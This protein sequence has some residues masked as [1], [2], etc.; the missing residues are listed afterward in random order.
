MQEAAKDFAAGTVAGMSCK[1]VEYPLDTVKVRLQ[2][3][4]SV[5]LSSTDCIARMLKE[6][7][8]LSFYRGV[9]APMCG[10]MFETAIAFVVYGRCLAYLDERRKS[11][12]DMIR[13]TDNLFAGGAS[14][15]ATA[16]VLTPIELVKCRL[17]VQE[18]LAPAQRLH[19]GPL[20]CVL[21]TLRTEGIRGMFLG[22]TPCL[23]REIPGNAVWYGVYS[24]AK[25]YLPKES[26]SGQAPMYQVAMAGSLAGIAYWTAFFPADVVKTRIQVD[27][28]KRQYTL[29]GAF[30]DV[31]REGGF[32]ALYKGWGITVARAIP[33]HAA[34]FVTYEFIRN[35]LDLYF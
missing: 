35:N 32:A 31:Y 16:L 20:H 1:Y 17:Q 28:K 2:D 33:A 15:I 19:N 9:T 11:R 25:A 23:L 27:T 22:L 30:R 10:C 5:Y 3:S 6:E 13:L 34:L 29:P 14:G 26:H 8:V 21:H 12:G 7:G 24:T 4:R 18:T